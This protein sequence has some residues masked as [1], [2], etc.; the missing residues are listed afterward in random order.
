MSFSDIYQ[1]AANCKEIQFY[2]CFLYL[3][4]HQLNCLSHVV[5]DHCPFS[6]PTSSLLPCGVPAPFHPET[7]CFH[8]YHLSVITLTPSPVLLNGFFNLMS[9]GRE[10]SYIQIYIVHTHTHIQKSVQI[11]HLA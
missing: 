10:Y 6:P 2:L 7:L 11:A 1:W 8:L 9:L 5:S 4:C 3:C